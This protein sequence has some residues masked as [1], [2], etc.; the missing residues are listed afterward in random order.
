M[1]VQAQAA[2]VF[3]ILTYDFTGDGNLDILLAG[4]KY[5]LEVETGP[6]DAGIGTLLQ[7]DGQGGFTW[8]NNT[9][10]GFWAPDEVRDLALLKGSGG[11]ITVLVG[12]NDGSA[13]VFILNSNASM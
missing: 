3:G 13:Q 6:S 5:G 12:N 9:T 8:V 7:G 2:P 1:P 10:S 11:K 4:N